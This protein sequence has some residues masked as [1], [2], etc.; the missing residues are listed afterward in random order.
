MKATESKEIYIAN[1]IL[2][3]VKGNQLTKEYLI[4][5]KE[6]QETNNLTISIFVHVVHQSCTNLSW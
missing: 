2:G 4:A 6:L 5:A 1:F 3:S